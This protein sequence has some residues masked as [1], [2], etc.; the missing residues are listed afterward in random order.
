MFSTLREN[1][2]EII[3]DG[4]TRVQLVMKPP[5]HTT[6]LACWKK[7]SSRIAVT[8][9]IM[10]LSIRLSVSLSVRLSDRCKDFQEI[11]KVNIANKSN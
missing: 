7:N 3:V 9:F 6:F 8:R 5:P 11:C 1:L 4:N 2:C 10:T